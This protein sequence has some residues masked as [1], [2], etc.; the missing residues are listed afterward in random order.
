HNDVG[1]CVLYYDGK[2]LLIDIGSE[3]YTRQTFG[4]ERYTI[5][6]MRSSYHNVPLINGVEQKEGAKYAAKA[7]SFVNNKTNASFAVDISAAYPAEAKVSS[8]IRRYDLKR[9]QSF[10]ITDTYKLLSNEGNN[11]LHFMTSASTE[12]KKDGLLELITGEVKMNME[13]DPKVFELVIEPITI[14]DSRLLE[15]WPPIVN[16][17]ILK[18]RNKGTQGSHRIIFRKAS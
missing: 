10:T 12:K 9:Q 13:Y 8:W 2:P 16:R 18:I 1:T 4:P 11:A 7:V 6:T 14:K 5:W 15:S 3:T 17:L